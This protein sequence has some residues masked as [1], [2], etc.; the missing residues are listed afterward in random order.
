MG[1]KTRALNRKYNSVDYSGSIAV[2]ERDY[3]NLSNKKS[4]NGAL[5]SFRIL[6]VSGYRLISEHIFS[7]LILAMVI[8]VSMEIPRRAMDFADRL[9][10]KTVLSQ[11][12][13]RIIDLA[14]AS[15]GLLL[16]LPVFLILPILIKLDSPGP[17]FFKQ[18]RVGINRRRGERRRM[19]AVPVNSD[20]KTDRRKDNSAGK[21]FV[22]LKFRTMR[23]D[24]EK[25]SGPVWASK[26]DSRITKLGRFLR[27]SRLD[28]IPQLINVLKGDMSLVGPRPERP[29]FVEKLSKEIESY[30]TRLEVKPG[31]TGLAQVENGYDQTTDDVRR[32]VS[33]DIDYIKRWNILRD[34][35]IMFKTVIVM[36]TGKGM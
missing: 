28:E 7:H 27:I 15:V 14:G 31:I 30:Q 22:I 4:S 35:K 12:L 1:I 2:S 36:I 10:N 26:N 8:A 25:Q 5:N 18:L 19:N 34:I 11:I 20:R 21:P 16:C 29:F 13:K 33:F 17:V 24:A 3:S 6:A 9:L 23:N 32:K